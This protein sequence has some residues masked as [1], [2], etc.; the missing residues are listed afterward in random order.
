MMREEMHDAVYPSAGP[1]ATKYVPHNGKL[2]AIPQVSIF[3]HFPVF[4]SPP[5]P[6]ST[7]ITKKSQNISTTISGP[8]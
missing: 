5:L 4:I 3:S 2:L 8:Y 7:Q 6:P 1:R